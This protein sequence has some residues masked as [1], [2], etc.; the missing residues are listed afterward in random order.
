MLKII[1][2]RT[3]AAMILNI[4]LNLWLIPFMG[5]AGAA[6]ATTISYYFATFAVMLLFTTETRR[7]ALYLMAP[8]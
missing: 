2:I 6:L 7:N 4:S 1:P 5:I 8:L 3:A